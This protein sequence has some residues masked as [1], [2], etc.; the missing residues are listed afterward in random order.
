MNLVGSPAGTAGY[1]KDL[2]SRPVVTS[3]SHARPLDADTRIRVMSSTVK[4]GEANHD[5]D[6][7]GRSSQARPGI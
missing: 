1:S 4:K 7:H 5:R 6:S 2:S 3:F